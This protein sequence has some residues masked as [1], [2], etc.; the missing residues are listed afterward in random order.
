MRSCLLYSPFAYVKSQALP[1]S[2]CHLPSCKHRSLFLHTE[3]TLTISIRDCSCYE[4]ATQAY[5]AACAEAREPS[6]RPRMFPDDVRLAASAH[7]HRVVARATTTTKPGGTRGRGGG[8]GLAVVAAGAGQRGTLYDS[9]EL[10]AMVMRLNR[11]L[12]GDGAGAGGGGEARRPRKAAGSWLNAPKVFLRKIKSA[13]LG[14][15]RRGDG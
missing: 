14:G 4:V 1:F 8:G 9:F 2:V 11:V 7:P 5:F 10:N 3:R 12:I 13:F 15:G 6:A